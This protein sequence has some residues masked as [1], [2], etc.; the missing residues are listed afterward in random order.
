MKTFNHFSYDFNI[1]ICIYIHICFCFFQDSFA[2]LAHLLQIDL[3]KNSLTVLP[4]NFGELVKLK[5]LDLFQNHIEE[6][7][8]T[9]HKL[10]NLQWLDLKA[11]PIQDRL[12]SIVG[13]CL[14]PIECQKC[15]KNVSNMHFI[16]NC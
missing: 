5:R 3:S 9:F 12:Q 14:K 8:I 13:D 1:Y 15:A 7:P 16:K 10:T 6:L 4:S 2:K 11:N